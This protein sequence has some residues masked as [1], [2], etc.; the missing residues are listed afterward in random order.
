MKRVAIVVGMLLLAS[1]SALADELGSMEDFVA[2]KVAPFIMKLKDL[3]GSYIRFTT[4]YISGGGWLWAMQRFAGDGLPAYTR[5]QTVTIGSEGYLIAYMVEAKGGDTSMLQFGRPDPNA[6]E[7]EPI[8][9]NSTLSIALLGQRGVTVMT[10]V[11]PFELA[12]ELADFQRLLDRYQEMVASRNAV[13]QP[14]AAQA[15][16]HLQ[17]VAAALKMYTDDYDGVLPPMNKPEAFRKALDEYVENAEMFRDPET[18]EF[19]GINPTLSGR[20]IKEIKEPGKT[21]AI[22][23]VKPGKDGNR[24]VIFVDGSTKR[25][26]ETEWADLKASSKIP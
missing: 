16:D 23:Q 5:G 21:I 13:N 1:A 8:T 3:D 7:P 26:T 22:Y 24:G 4:P 6:P 14:I 19:Y 17:A 12:A 25:L 18:K 20:K 15:P 2:G 9:E 11:R 10:R